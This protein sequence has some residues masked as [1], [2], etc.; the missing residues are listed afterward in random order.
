MHI[1]ATAINT[2]LFSDNA[3]QGIRLREN[4][5][6]SITVLLDPLLFLSILQWFSALYGSW[7]QHHRKDKEIFFQQCINFF[8]KGHG[9]GMKVITKSC[10]LWFFSNSLLIH[11][12]FNQYF[13]F[14]GFQ[15]LAS[16][17]WH[18][19]VFFLQSFT[20]K[21]Q[22]FRLESHPSTLDISLRHYYL[23]EI[24]GVSPGR[25]KGTNL[26]SSALLYGQRTQ[27]KA[28]L[29]TCRKWQLSLRH[30]ECLLL[31]TDCKWTHSASGQSQ[32]AA[33]A[34]IPSWKLIWNTPNTPST[35]DPASL[36][37]LQDW[38]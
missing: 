18:L 15:Q 10:S 32:P 25:D 37:L 35:Q 16:S 12:H 27:R 3:V 34:L 17:Y 4:W 9:G 8:S 2:P 13:L 14:F 19:V 6:V 38:R 20:A 28:L 31:S 29:K 26:N 30:L 22:V 33:G 7:V 23:N 11:T 1:Q 5:W 21:P 36:S 24:L